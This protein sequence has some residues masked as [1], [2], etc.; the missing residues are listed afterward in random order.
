MKKYLTILLT[1]IIF[2]TGWCNK[3]I[4]ASYSKENVKMKYDKKQFKKVFTE[5][6]KQ[7]V[8]LQ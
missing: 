1:F 8:I 7:C 2:L 6:G 4:P 5:R 3:S